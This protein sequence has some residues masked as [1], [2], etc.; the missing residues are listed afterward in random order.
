MQVLERLGALLSRSRNPRVQPTRSASCAPEEPEQTLPRDLFELLYS[1]EHLGE[2]FSAYRLLR[3]PVVLVGVDNQPLV[4]LHVLGTVGTSAVVGDDGNLR[5]VFPESQDFAISLTNLTD[6]VVL[7]DIGGDV[8]RTDPEFADRSDRTFWSST[9]RN[10]RRL[11]RPNILFPLATTRV[12]K[13][14]AHFHDTGENRRLRAASASRDELESY[15][16]YI[17]TKDRGVPAFQ[18]TR[19]CFLDTVTVCHSPGVV[20]AELVGLRA[21]RDEHGDEEAVLRAAGMDTTAWASMPRADQIQAVGE[22]RRRRATAV[23]ARSRAVVAGETVPVQDAYL[24]LEKFN[25]T[26]RSAPVSITFEITKQQQ[27]RPLQS[28]ASLVPGAQTAVEEMATS[29]RAAHLRKLKDVVGW[30]NAD[31]VICLGPDP[32]TVIM[33]CGHRSVHR[34]CIEGAQMHQ[35]PLCRTPVTAFVPDECVPCTPT[36]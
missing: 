18:Q 9:H 1:K 11:N 30:K 36:L 24:L 27:L 5:A 3:Y 12:E 10:D 15:P 2:V 6:T 21:V 25:F 16:I 7:A 17:Y 28:K 29:R 22:A 4:V 33:P 14:G 35:C 20:A 23:G 32:D 34:K 8:R 13:N 19:W 26:V 31:C